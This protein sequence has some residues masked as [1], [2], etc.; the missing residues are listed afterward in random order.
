MGRMNENKNSFSNLIILTGP[1][2][3]GKTRSLLKMIEGFSKRP[4]KICGIISP[5]VFV[6]GI[7]TAIDLRDVHT[8]Q[9]RR[10]ADLRRS[11]SSRIMTERWVFI[12]DALQWGNQVL[13]ES[14]P[15]DLLIVDELGPIE[16]EHGQGFQW[17]IFAL[18][19]H[20][21]KA[22]V[23]VIRPELLD[24]AARLWPGSEVI[25]INND[26]AFGGQALTSSIN[27]LMAE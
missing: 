16:L 10:L 12:E 21:Y 17:G 4:I 24:Q 25:E 11:N 6:D 13:R 5:A 22:A 8:G 26:Q 2:E 20:Q 15:C 18:N 23:V 27:L 9:Q 7:K 3:I 1:R 19:S 14:V